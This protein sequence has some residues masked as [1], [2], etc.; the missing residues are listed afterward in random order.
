MPNLYDLAYALGLAA[1]AP[2][3]LAVPGM[4]RK[5]LRA[6]RERMGPVHGVSRDASRPA[7]MIHAV[8]LGEINATRAMVAQLTA[9]RPDLQFIITVTTDTGY[10]RGRELYG[11]NPSVTLV[12]YPLDFSIA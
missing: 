8:S 1:A 6:L 2:V 11:N 10:A 4:R 3:W 9:A 5:V 7:G 12:R